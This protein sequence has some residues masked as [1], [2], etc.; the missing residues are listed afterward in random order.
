M[1]RKA[2]L[3]KNHIQPTEAQIRANL[4]LSGLMDA[5]SQ[6]C[7]DGHAYAIVNSDHGTGVRYRFDL[8]HELG[9]MMLHRNALP[10]V[11]SNSNRNNLIEEQAHR[12]ASE[13]LMPSRSFAKGFRVPTIDGLKLIF[14]VAVLSSPMMRRRDGAWR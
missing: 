13:F 10:G 1:M 11:F 12:F 8:A 4:S 7:S 6:I 14:D 2:K 5:F 3:P 9:H